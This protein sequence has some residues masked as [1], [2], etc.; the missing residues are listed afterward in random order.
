MKTLNDYLSTLDL[1]LLQDV[2]SN[3]C[4]L[5][6]VAKGFAIYDYVYD[7]KLRLKSIPH[8]DL[9][10]ICTDTRV[11]I[12]FLFLDDEFVGISRQVAR[13]SCIEHFW[14]DEESCK[15]VK[16]YI[17]SLKEQEEHKH[18][19]I[20]EFS[21]FEEYEAHAQAMKELNKKFNRQ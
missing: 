19:Y 6:S 14:K 1:S 12:H 11:G 15:K 7:D 13:K 9:T 5:E 3:Y 20:S 18:S 10:W 8:E 17:F 4:D 2:W 21:N 16:D